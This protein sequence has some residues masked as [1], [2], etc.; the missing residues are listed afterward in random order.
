MKPNQKASRNRIGLAIVWE[1]YTGEQ[2]T[3][4]G[5]LH[6]VEKIKGRYGQTRI[7]RLVFDENDLLVEQL[8]SL[9]DFERD[10]ADSL[11]R[12]F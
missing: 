6:I 12:W 7:A 8:E 9:N 4:E 3:K 10:G 1:T 11:C 5:A 2:T